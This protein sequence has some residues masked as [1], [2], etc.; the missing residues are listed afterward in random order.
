MS[1]YRHRSPSEYITHMLTE[2]GRLGFQIHE[3]EAS[4]RPPNRQT[5]LSDIIDWLDDHPGE[6]YAN[7]LDWKSFDFEQLASRFERQR[8]AKPRIEISA[9][10]TKM[11]NLSVRWHPMG[12]HAAPP[13]W[14]GIRDDYNMIGQ[15][16][17]SAAPD[18]RWF[19]G[20]QEIGFNTRPT[21]ELMYIRGVGNLK[22]EPREYGPYA[23]FNRDVVDGILI[24]AVRAAYENLIEQLRHS[25]E[26]EVLDAF[27]FE[28]REF[29]RGHDEFSNRFPVRR[30]VDWSLE[31]ASVLNERRNREAAV[32]REAEARADLA[33]FDERHGCTLALLADALAIAARPGK[34]GAV[35]STEQINRAAAKD[36][37]TRGATLNAGDVR[38]FRLL[39]EEFQPKSLPA[40]LR[41][42]PPVR[43]S[44][45]GG[46]VVSLVDRPLRGE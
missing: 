39:L 44:L 35:P 8:D 28:V 26:V 34:G 19:R 20:D 12:W 10:I 29:D 31:N 25:F 6:N 9:A 23:T 13:N 21:N 3:I 38:R 4:G 22:P 14:S 36:L 41:P 27:D 16:L 5:V 40:E 43:S 37:R 42:T 30:V 11:E 45:G 15:K 1:W 24:G 18:F 2:T 32:V 7:L 33:Q 17:W 46:N